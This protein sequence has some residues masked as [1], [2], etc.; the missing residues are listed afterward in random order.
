MSPLEVSDSRREVTDPVFQG[1]IPTTDTLDFIEQIEGNGYTL[2]HT[3]PEDEGEFY[4]ALRK[5]NERG[6]D[7]VR[8]MRTATRDGRRISLN[9]LFIKN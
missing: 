1:L 3:G 6:K 5:A 9:L 4:T 7:L 2:T 8:Y